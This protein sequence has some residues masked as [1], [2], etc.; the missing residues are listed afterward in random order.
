MS[1]IPC[2]Q[3]VS[4]SF[5]YFVLIPALPDADDIS[6]AA[7]PQSVPVLFQCSLGLILTESD[8]FSYVL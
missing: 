2:L 4:A 7:C 1:R 8:A 6:H 5:A 3:T